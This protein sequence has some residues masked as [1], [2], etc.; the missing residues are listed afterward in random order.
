MGRERRWEYGKKGEGEKR[1]PQESAIASWIRSN[2]D[3]VMISN[4]IDIWKT[5]ISL[6]NSLWKIYTGLIFLQFNCTLFSKSS[7]YSYKLR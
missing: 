6:L 3:N 4:K 5:D 7:D 1:G 2:F